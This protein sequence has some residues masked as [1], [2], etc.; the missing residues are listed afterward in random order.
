ML[1][2]S[3]FEPYND[4]A[5]IYSVLCRANEN[6][7]LDTRVGC[8]VGCSLYNSMTSFTDEIATLFSYDAVYDAKAWEM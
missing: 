8:R 4:Q 1:T 7:L 6:E 3:A 5:G 2:S